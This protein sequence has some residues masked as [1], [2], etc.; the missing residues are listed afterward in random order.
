MQGERTKGQGTRLDGGRQDDLMDSVLA[1]DPEPVSK[2]LG[3]SQSGQPFV[4]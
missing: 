3:K 2:A 1:S 4:P